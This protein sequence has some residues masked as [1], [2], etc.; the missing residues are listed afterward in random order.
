MSNE[1]QRSWSLPTQAVV[2]GRP[3]AQAGSPVNEPVTFTSTYHAGA[4]VSYA[5]VGN[6]TWD[7][8]EQTVGALEG[9]AALAFPSGMAAI[10]A[11]LSCVPHGGVVLAPHHAYSGTTSLLDDLHSS[12]AVQ[13][14]RVDIADSEDVRRAL[15]DEPAADLLIAESPTNPM[16]EVADLPAVIAAAHAVGARVMVD[17]TFATPL[18]Q[19]PLE[20][21]ADVVIHS[22]TK[23]LSGHS[24]VLLGVTVTPRNAAGEE[25][26][27]RLH[28][29]RTSRGSIPGPMEVWL[30]LRGLRTL[31]VRVERS[32]ANAAELAGR[33]SEHPAVQ[34]VRY[35]G[36]GATV[37]IEVAPPGTSGSA[38]PVV[39]AEQVCAATRL[40]A[41]STSLGGVE[42]QIERRRRHAAEVSTVPENLIRLSV[43]IESVDDLWRDLEAALDTLVT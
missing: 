16:L 2:V 4:E 19:R 39:A 18:L 25:L 36:W 5:R 41:H 9:G 22:A 30:A 11:V 3:P 32:G 38:D 27:E 21:G 35:P 40:W 37:G 12:G 1:T 34:R 20:S 33:L 15:A 43:G 42:S 31:A 10:A 26:S 6:P 7:A 8:F 28:T 17:N 14:R 24:D 23:Y 29:H 13:V